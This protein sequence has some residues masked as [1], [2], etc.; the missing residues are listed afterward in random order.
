MVENF[1]DLQ[2]SNLEPP[3]VNKIYIPIPEYNVRFAMSSF[4]KTIAMQIKNVSI[5]YQN[6]SA[7][8]QQWSKTITVRP[9]V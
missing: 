6:F 2:P 7:Q 9:L 4:A 8:P 1:Y 5:A 3:S